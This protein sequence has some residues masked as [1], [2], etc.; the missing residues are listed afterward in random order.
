MKIFWKMKANIWLPV[1]WK[2]WRIYNLP[3]L[4][5]GRFLVRLFW[6]AVGRHHYFDIFLMCIIFFFLVIYFIIII[7]IV[8]AWWPK[9]KLKGCSIGLMTEKGVERSQC[10]RG[11]TVSH[12]PKGRSR[13]RR[14]RNESW[15]SVVF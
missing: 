6:W 14:R 5:F 4:L 2:R 9:M 11:N 12:R 8:G 10:W 15:Y 7:I 13:L 1:C 3:S